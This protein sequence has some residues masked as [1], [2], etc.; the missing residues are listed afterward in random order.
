MPTVAEIAAYLEAFAP[1]RSAA[2]WDNVGLLL[3][4]PAGT[5][6]KVMACLTITPDVAEEA[7][8]EGVSLIVSH[9]PILFHG[10]KQLTAERGD[11]RVVLP[12]AR[13]GVAV[14]SAHTAFDNC[15]GG[16]NDILC[17]RLGVRNT[18]PLRAREGPR[19]YKLAV[20]VPGSDLGRVSD[21]LFA[22]GAGVIGKYEQ[23]SFRVAGK[24]TFFGTEETNPAVGQKG[25]REEADEWR[26]EV[27]VPEAKLT[28]AVLAVR[29]AHSYEEPAF[30]VYPLKAGPGGGEG[31]VGELAEPTTLGE[32]ANRAKAE[33]T[34]AAV[35]VVGDL[36]RSVRR[37]AVACG[38]AGE[39]LSDSVQSKA[40]VFVTGEMRFHDA[41]AARAAGVG[42]IL[43][44]HYATE[45][46]AV[47]ELA[48]KLAG[49][50][51]G[52]ITWASRRELDPLGGIELG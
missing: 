44:G 41:L 37:V 46:P 32:L 18:Q 12:L 7:V 5:V 49:D 9:H 13:A 48:A 16:V 19:G 8:A 17:R 3:G 47:E 26:L 39:F 20:Y 30:D 1:T 52:V 35:Q 45:R 33:L 10:A 27:V 4:D 31:R 23:C 22:A 40:D 43:P 34:A 28:A 29:K 11:G 25:R 36:S 21:A 42:V 24:G 15:Q 38:A 51:P 14:Y 6:Q 50:W 2:D